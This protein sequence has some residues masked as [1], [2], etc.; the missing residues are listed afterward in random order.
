MYRMQ[1]RSRQNAMSSSRVWDTVMSFG[2][3]VMPSRF[4]L[5]TMSF[6]HRQ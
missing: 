6:R 5:E 2:A 4:I 1:P 3:M